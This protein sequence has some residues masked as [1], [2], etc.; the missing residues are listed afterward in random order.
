M[1]SGTAG[2]A[3][4]VEHPPLRVVQGGQLR[5]DLLER[6][7]GQIESLLASRPDGCDE[8]TS[9]VWLSEAERLLPLAGHFD[10]AR[11]LQ[12]CAVVREELA[13]TGRPC[14]RQAYRDDADA[15]ALYEQ[16]GEAAHA[17]TCYTSAAISALRSEEVSEA[18]E[19]AVRGLVAFE[20]LTPVELERDRAAEARMAGMLA[21]LCCQFLDHERALRFAEIAVGQIAVGHRRWGSAAGLLARIALVR[22]RELAGDP[23]AGAA[24]GPSSRREHLL[25]TVDHIGRTL[26]DGARGASSLVIGPLLLAEVMVERGEAAR[27]W[28]LLERADHAARGPQVG[29][30]SGPDLAGLQLARGRCLVRLAR[31]VEALAELDGALG[32][33]HPDRDLVDHVHALELRSL[34]RERS[35]DAAGALADL[36]RLTDLVWVRHRRQIGGFMEQIWG[37]AGAEGRRRDL[38]AREQ[39]LIRTAEQDP[40]TGLANRRG[41]ERFCSTLAPTEPICLVMI[42]I[43]HFK[44]VNDRFGHATGDATLREVAEVLGSSVR[45]VDRVARWG[46]EEFLLALP[47]NSVDFGAEVASRVRR[48]AQEHH[49]EHLAPGLGLTVSAGVA[50]GP[51]SELADVLHRADAALYA[52]KRAGRNRVVTG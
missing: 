28:E 37:R 12:G 48:R 9:R 7:L 13:R 30:T 29:W 21:L 14:E 42:D 47:S 51:A 23:L 15:A 33:L 11:L 5:L 40:L 45:S 31:P 25:D 50:C 36:R 10:R 39:V 41:V 26:A 20:S 19:L 2:A 52:A 35:G 34:A 49:W 3:T 38:E 44:T 6:R 43:D 18:L 46:G 22:A 17:A 27:A 16:L 4:S 1:N 32:A 8:A 24:T